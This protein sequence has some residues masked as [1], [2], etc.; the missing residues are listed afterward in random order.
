MTDEQLARVLEAFVST[1]KGRGAKEPEDKPP[2]PPPS[3]LPQVR[4]AKRR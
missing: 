1:V 4:K 2:E 3:N